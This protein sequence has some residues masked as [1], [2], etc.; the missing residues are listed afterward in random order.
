[1]CV[2]NVSQPNV[3]RDLWDRKSGIDVRTEMESWS[4]AITTNKTSLY[5]IK[6]DLMAALLFPHATW[7]GIPS[8]TGRRSS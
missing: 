4:R 2:R 6:Y 1:M 7:L 3:L 8:S 5:V